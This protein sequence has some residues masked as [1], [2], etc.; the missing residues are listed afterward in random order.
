M[1]AIEYY[2]KETGWDDMQSVEDF[3]SPQDI[4]RMLIEFGRICVERAIT[5][6]ENKAEVSFTPY[7]EEAWSQTSILR[8]DILDFYDDGERDEDF[9]YEQLRDREG[10]EITVDKESIRNAFSPQEIN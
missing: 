5:E 10:F 4:V 6:I 7:D 8:E 2:L 3:D 9:Q 1:T